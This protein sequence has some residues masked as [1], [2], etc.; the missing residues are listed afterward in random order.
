MKDLGSEKPPEMKASQ[1]RKDFIFRVNLS[2]E[3]N[4]ALKLYSSAECQ[5]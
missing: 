2:Q 3:L 5:D 4:T 1:G